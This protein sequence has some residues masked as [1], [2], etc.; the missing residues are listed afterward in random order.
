MKLHSV[1]EVAY[2]LTYYDQ[3]A[4]AEWRYDQQ[5]AV[6]ILTENHGDCIRHVYITIILHTVHKIQHNYNHN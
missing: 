1:P 5:N 2:T 3:N 6:A 4:M